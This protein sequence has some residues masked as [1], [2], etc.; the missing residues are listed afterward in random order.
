[1]GCMPRNA[2]SD[3]DEDVL[4]QCPIIGQKI[5]DET[6]RTN[7][8]PVPAASPA[9]LAVVLPARTFSTALWDYQ[10]TRAPQLNWPSPLPAVTILARLQDD[11][12]RA[13]IGAP[14]QR[15]RLIALKRFPRS[16]RTKLDCWSPTGPWGMCVGRSVRA[17]GL[18]R[19]QSRYAAQ[20]DQ[21]P[22]VRKGQD[23]R[24]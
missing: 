19:R 21:P 12:L 15:L 9:C 24:R 14:M 20:L 18:G 4:F 22:R 1:M 16:R 10:K 6:K 23:T 13:A 8:V 5:A 7:A 11:S 17:L 3:A 2:L